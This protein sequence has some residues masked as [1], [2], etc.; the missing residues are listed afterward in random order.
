M[1]IPISFMN[2]EAKSF[3]INEVSEYLNKGSF[4]TKVNSTNDK[5]KKIIISLPFLLLA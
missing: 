1:L 4:N 5:V 3:T 2:V